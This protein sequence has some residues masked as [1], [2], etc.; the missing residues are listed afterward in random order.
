M[1]QIEI[2]DNH[3]QQLNV[4]NENF[5]FVNHGQIDESIRIHLIEIEHV[6]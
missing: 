1:I 6:R 2:K 3:N 5:F 4:E